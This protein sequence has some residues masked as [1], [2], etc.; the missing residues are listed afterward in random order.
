[1]EFLEGG[2]L[3]QAVETSAKFGVGHIAYIARECLKALIHIHSENLIHRDIK[4][5]NIMLTTDGRVKIIDFG[6]CT[7]LNVNPNPKGM[8]GSP[9][10]MAPE[11]IKKECHTFMVDVYSL[12]MVLYELLSCKSL[13]SQFSA[14][15]VMFQ[16]GSGN[17]LDLDIIRES[18]LGLEED[19]VE[20]ME[21]ILTYDADSR[22]NPIKLLALDFIK[23]ASTRAEMRNMISHI[24]LSKSLAM[25]G[26]S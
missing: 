24:F 9:F 12:G 25:Q 7:D 15:Y 19:S 4:P 21:K 10:W 3:C 6:L 18:P 5:H 14:L 26:M 11:V 17:G 8:L 2:T 1:M 13:K 20:F 16:T 22:P 23:K